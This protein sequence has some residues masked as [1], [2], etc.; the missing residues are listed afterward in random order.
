[1]FRV[2]W[3][4]IWWR[5]D[6]WISKK[7]KFDYLKNEKSFRGEK[8][9]ILSF[10]HIK[11]TSKNVV[12]TIFKLKFQKIEVV[13][14]K[15]HFFLIGPSCVPRSI[16]HNIAYWR[17]SFVRKYCVFNPFLTEAVI[18]YKPVHWFAEQ[19]NGVASIW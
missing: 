4:G 10:R 5:H 17:G 11:Q 2:S 8:K 13:S 15:T 1:M 3:L 7:L 12:D 14:G 19:I 16:C 6:I 9:Q 18:I